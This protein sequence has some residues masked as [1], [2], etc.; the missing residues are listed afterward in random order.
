MEYDWGLTVLQAQLI[1]RVQSRLRD[2]LLEDPLS[3]NHMLSR[4]EKVNS[5]VRIITGYSQIHF[6]T[7]ATK[8]LVQVVWKLP[9][10]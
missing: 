8:P 6:K 7:I 3:I 2:L 9:S 1:Q 10:T 5:W 4:Y